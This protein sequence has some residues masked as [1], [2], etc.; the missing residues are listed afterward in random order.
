M[1]ELPPVMSVPCYRRASAVTG[2][3]DQAEALVAGD[4]DGEDW[5]APERTGGAGPSA[6]DDSIPTIGDDTAGKVISVRRSQHDLHAGHVSGLFCTPDACQHQSI[7]AQLYFPAETSL[8]RPSFSSA[9]QNKR[10]DM[11]HLSPAAAVP[12]SRCGTVS[13]TLLTSKQADDDE[14]SVP[15]IDDLD[16]GNEEADEVLLVHPAS[17]P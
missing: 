15:D 16:I 2:A 9:A 3:A 7:K 12:L 13:R 10:N 11:H 17:V 14:D 8:S 6:D 4:G 5:V 1:A